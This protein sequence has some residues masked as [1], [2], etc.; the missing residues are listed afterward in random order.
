[1]RS[2]NRTLIFGLLAGILG[3]CAYMP[4]SPAPPE[5]RVVHA[6][7]A[8]KVVPRPAVVAHSDAAAGQSKK[9]TELTEEATGSAE[10]AYAAGPMRPFTPEW[11]AREKAIDDAIARKLHI[12]AC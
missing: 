8:R 4:A 2:F 3:G 6:P 11:F 12:C 1:M 10:S 5:A 9:L 7:V